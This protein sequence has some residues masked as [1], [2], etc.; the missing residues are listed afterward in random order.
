MTGV[1]C[2]GFDFFFFERPGTVEGEVVIGEGAGVEDLFEFGFV[3]KAEDAHML[4]GEG[5]GFAA[6]L[7]A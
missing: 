2:G 6:E 1:P 3:P 5:D 7:A 4:N